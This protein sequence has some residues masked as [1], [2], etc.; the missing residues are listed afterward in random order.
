MTDKI[1]DGILLMREEEK[2]ARD[3]YLKL[4][5]KYDVKIFANIAKAEQQHMDA[6]KILLENYEIEDPIVSNEI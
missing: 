4:T 2:V 5:E 1:K 3:V 6:I